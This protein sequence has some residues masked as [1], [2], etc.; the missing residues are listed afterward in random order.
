MIKSIG[1]DAVI[2]K[3]LVPRS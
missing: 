2:S 3:F 1:V